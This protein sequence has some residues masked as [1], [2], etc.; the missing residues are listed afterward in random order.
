MDK[1]RKKERRKRRDQRTKS[2]VRAAQLSQAEGIGEETGPESLFSL[3]KIKGRA[4]GALGD[5]SAPDFGTPPGSSSEEEAGGGSSQDMDSEE[6]QRRWGAA[7]EAATGLACPQAPGAGCPWGRRRRAAACCC[8]H[9][10][11]PPLPDCA[12]P[13]MYRCRTAAGTTP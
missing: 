4:G 9:Q 11:S 5:A 12:V 10:A 7:L 3:A 6:E 2:R 8:P 13:L 1:R